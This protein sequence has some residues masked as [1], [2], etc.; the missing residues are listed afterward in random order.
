M[1]FIVMKNVSCG[2][3]LFPYQCKKLI[4][5]FLFCSVRSSERRLK[6]S[7]VLIWL[8]PLCIA[9]PM[10]YFTQHMPPEEGEEEDEENSRGG[11]GGTCGSMMPYDLQ[12]VYNIFTFLTSYIIPG[13][14]NNFFLLECKT[15]SNI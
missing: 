9:S 7:V 10:L 4:S 11:S 1:K 2:K 5:Q 12:T 14:L 3:Y 15:K 8:M 13:K 6:M